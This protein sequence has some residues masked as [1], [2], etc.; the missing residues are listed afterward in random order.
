METRKRIAL[1]IVAATAT[2]LLF[3]C[4]LKST[5]ID[6]R[7]SDFFT[8]LNGDRTDTYTNLDPSTA[9]YS[10]AKPFGFWDTPFPVGSEPYTYSGLNTTPSSDVTMTISDKTSSMGVYHFVMVNIGTTSDNWVISDIQAPP[11]GSAS[12]IFH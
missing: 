3:S 11:G 9:A 6:E 5:S 2:M 7:I 12:T 8:S 10:L 1:L 4:A